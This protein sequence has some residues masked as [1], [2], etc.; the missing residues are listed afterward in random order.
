MGPS[1]AG[2]TSLLNCITGKVQDGVEGQ[3]LVDGLDKVKISYVPQFDSMYEQFTIFETLMFASRMKNSNFNEEEHLHTAERF[4]VLKT[5]I[6]V[7]MISN[8]LL[9]WATAAL[10]VKVPIGRENGCQLSAINGSLSTIQLRDIVIN[11]EARLKDAEAMHFLGLHGMIT[12][13]PFVTAIFF[14]LHVTT[15]RREIQNGWYSMSALF[16]SFI[17]EG[18]F[19][20]TLSSA[21]SVAIFVSLS[22]MLDL[23]LWRLLLYFTYVTLM[24]LIAWLIGVIIGFVLQDNFYNI[25]LTLC[26]IEVPLSIMQSRFIR[27]DKASAIFKPF[28]EINCFDQAYRGALS[29]IYGFG[30]CDQQLT[31]AKSL[32]ADMALS[33]SP[34][35][36]ISDSL[37]VVELKNETISRYASIL[38]IDEDILYEVSKKSLDFMEQFDEGTSDEIQASFILQDYGIPNDGRN[39]MYHYTC[40]TLMVMFALPLVYLAMKRALKH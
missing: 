16:C 23:E 5:P 24:T 22:E 14:A 30:R 26:A 25:F 33:Q 31:K 32:L 38:G 27:P 21:I 34:Y 15:V 37:G 4:R 29:V 12:F 35:K 20:V 1:G 6:L 28:F 9:V 2:K 10:M 17:V 11:K 3:V 8:T 39:F 13:Y 18:I 7:A 40:L 19:E 36:I